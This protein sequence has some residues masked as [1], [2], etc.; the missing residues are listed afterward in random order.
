MPDPAC[1]TRQNGD[2]DVHNA[3]GRRWWRIGGASGL[4]DGTA[5][6]LSGRFP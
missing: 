5:E 2:V 6:S 3:L 4:L 1:E